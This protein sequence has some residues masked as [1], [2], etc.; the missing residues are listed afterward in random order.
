MTTTL[1]RMEV[2][3]IA[4]IVWH[5]CEHRGQPEARAAV[6]PLVTQLDALIFPTTP[7]LALPSS[8]EATSFAA[9]ARMIRNTDPGANAG[10]PGISLP[11]GIAGN[12]ALP[13]GLEIDGL[14]DSDDRLL[15][16]AQALQNVFG[17]QASP[18]R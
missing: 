1:R 5:L 7:D 11:I 14:P 18:A 2:D 9:F 15:A 3:S 8:P 6:L 13:V 17:R 10:L 4:E 16:I 12:P